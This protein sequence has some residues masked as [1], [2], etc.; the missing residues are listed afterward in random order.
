MPA[1][2]FTLAAIA[3]MHPCAG[4]FADVRK[5]LPQRRRYTAAQAREA[6]VSFDH[7]VWA[8]SAF[9]RRDDDVER[10]LRLWL[11][12]CAAH[13]LHIYEKTETGDAPRKA[14]VAARQYAR[15]E[16]DSA[17]EGAAWAAAR[18]A[19][20]DAVGAAR[21]AEKAWQF[22][23]LIAWFSDEEPA[24]WPLPIRETA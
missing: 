8:A 9:A 22:D 16:I 1:P 14:I 15:G 12:D 7:I 17:A 4:T 3:K 13:V 6:G 21:D 5:A 20:W 18:A 2:A 24:D 10:R 19:A 11:A 23:R